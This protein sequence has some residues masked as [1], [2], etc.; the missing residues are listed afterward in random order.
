MFRKWW[1]LLCVF[2][3]CVYGQ[4]QITPAVELGARQYNSDSARA[5]QTHNFAWDQGYG[6]S[7]ITAPALRV[8][9]H[10]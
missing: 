1:L 8:Y 3:P 6:L 10:I 4:W 5:Q 9:K 2:A 7:L